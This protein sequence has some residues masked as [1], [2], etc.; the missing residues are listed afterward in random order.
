MSLYAVRRNPVEGQTSP[1]EGRTG[2]GSTVPTEAGAQ[3]E[4]LWGQE[5]PQIL[6]QGQAALW[7]EQRW[8]PRNPLLRI[9]RVLVSPCLQ[10][11]SLGARL[12]QAPCWWQWQS[13]VATRSLQ[14]GTG[15][16]VLALQQHSLVEH[17]PCAMSWGPVSSALHL[18][19]AGWSDGAQSLLSDLSSLG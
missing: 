8:W 2:W 16:W 19:V 3:V 9:A 6:L 5:G 12:C 7:G 4:G 1:T 13:F 10:S 17:S 11:K 18:H 15:L 14:E